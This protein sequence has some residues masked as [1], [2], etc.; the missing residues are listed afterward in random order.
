MPAFLKE[1]WGAKNH[2]CRGC[3]GD[4]LRVRNYPTVYQIMEDPSFLLSASL[5]APVKM[6]LA[7][8]RLPPRNYPLQIF[9]LLSRPFLPLDAFCDLVAP[10]GIFSGFRLHVKFGE[11]IRRKEGLKPFFGFQYL[12]QNAVGQTAILQHYQRFEFAAHAQNCGLL[13]E[14]LN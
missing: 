9:S 1:Q 3:I 8:S 4:Y 13:L 6:K 5:V 7:V 11:N 2:R 10:G 12:G 14:N